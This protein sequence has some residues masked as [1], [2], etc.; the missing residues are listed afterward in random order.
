MKKALLTKAHLPYSKPILSM[1]TDNS[2][3]GWSPRRLMELK[4]CMQKF[5][6]SIVKTFSDHCSSG[7]CILKFHLL[8]HVLEG[9]WTFCTLSVPD[10]S[11]FEQTA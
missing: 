1:S 10:T 4:D 8:D 2:R 7:L 5:K 3:K 6:R 9:W 11:L